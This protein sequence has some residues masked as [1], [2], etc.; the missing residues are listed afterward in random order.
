MLNKLTPLNLLVNLTLMIKGK[1][2]EKAYLQGADDLEETQKRVL[3]DILR[4]QA[5]TDFGKKYNFS[6]IT[7]VAQ[8][9]KTVP[10]HEY[11][12]LRPWI[13]S[14]NNTGAKAICSEE[15]KFYS[16]TSGT[17]GVPK[18]VPVLEST[19]KA[20]KRTSDLFFYYLWKD[21]DALFD[22]K[23]LGIVSPAVEGYMPNSGSP[24][25]STS[26]QIYKGIPKIVQSKYVVPVEVFAIEDYDLKYL[27]ILRLGMVH[28]DL[29]YISTANPST[30]VRLM[31]L[32]RTHWNDLVQDI[33][34]G[35]FFRWNELS[36]EVQKAVVGKL[37]ANPGRAEDLE[38]LHVDHD[39]VRL[40]HIWPDLQAVGVWTGGNSH[41]FFQQLKN[42]FSRKTL[43]RDLGYLSTEFRGSVPVKRD[44]NSGIPTF[45]DNFYEFIEESAFERGEMNFLGVHELRLGRRYYVFVTTDAGL[46]RYNMNDIVETTDFFHKV[47]MIRFV[48]KGKGVTNITGEKVYE[49]HIISAVTQ[50]EE[51]LGLKSNFYMAVADEHKSQYSL[52]YEPC[53]MDRAKL[54]SCWSQF[55]KIYEDSLRNINIEYES[56][57][58]SGRNSAGDFRILMP[59]TFEMFKI[60]HLQRGQREGQFKTVL[61][62]YKR[63]MHFEFEPFVEESPIAGKIESI[64]ADQSFNG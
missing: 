2:A 8:F 35:G 1:K 20:H 40:K 7:S 39:T 45:L 49:S 27:L 50:A 61:L 37:E 48:Q 23:I 24:R 4:K 47:P 28:E 16:V 52:F 12:A 51:K 46:Y 64:F 32:M 17:T 29:S 53:P 34:S 5:K 63:D 57:V 18:Y 33:S 55:Q 26:G 59:E 13:E 31:K 14:Q 44:S 22:G 56:K 58:K 38:T 21:R 3:F 54:Y 62:Q 19:M 15:P 42:E 9:R 60:F 11:E 41:V 36:E 30:I 43:I 10:I 25:G 6:S